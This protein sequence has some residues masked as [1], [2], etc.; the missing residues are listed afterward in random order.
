MRREDKVTQRL[1]QLQTLFRQDIPQA[2]QYKVA[3]WAIWALPTDPTIED[4]LYS[5]RKELRNLQEDK[6]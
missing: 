6:L 5:I 1:K 4:I 2:T 3:K